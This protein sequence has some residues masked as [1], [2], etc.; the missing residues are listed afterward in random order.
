MNKQTPI[1]PPSL[2]GG[3]YTGEPFAKGA[4]W[5]NFPATPDADYMTHFNL[6]SANPPTEALVQYPGGPRPGNNVQTMPGVDLTRYCNLAPCP[7]KQPSSQQQQQPNN[8][9]RFAKYGYL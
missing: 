2:N 1:P 4:A 3:L 5:A 7:Y 6:K 8:N 9:D